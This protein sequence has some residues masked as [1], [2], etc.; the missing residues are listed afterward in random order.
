MEQQRHVPRQRALRRRRRPRR[1]TSRCAASARCGTS[2]PA[3][4][5]A[6]SPPT[7][8][9]RRWASTSCRRRSC[10]T[11]RSARA[12]CSGSSTPTIA[13][14]TSR[15]TRS[16]PTCTT[17]CAAWPLFDLV[18]NNTDRKSGH[19]LI[20]ARRSH[21]GHRPRPVLRRRLQAAHGRLGV[22]RRADRLGADR[23]RRAASP[24]GCRWRSP[25][26]STTTR[27]RRCRSAPSGSS[28]NPVFPV[29]SSGRRYPWPM[30]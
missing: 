7:T 3:C 4:T 16:A 18:A 12:R 30:V 21:L 11:G 28:S 25:R 13:S 19:V 17:S 8:S 6:R 24:S 10:A 15:S 22:R 2:S 27:S 29:D 20:D 9:A 14:T 1:S 23:R 26:C 5:A